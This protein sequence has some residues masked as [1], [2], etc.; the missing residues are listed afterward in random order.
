MDAPSLVTPL[1]FA[2]W[3]YYDDAVSNPLN[4]TYAEVLLLY[5]L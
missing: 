1:K 3:T 2:F 4:S 5:I